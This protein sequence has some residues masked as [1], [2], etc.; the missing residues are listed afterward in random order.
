MNKGL[1][2]ENNIE[3]INLDYSKLIFPLNSGSLEKKQVF[4]INCNV[5]TILKCEKIKFNQN[6]K[7][8]QDQF[9]LT[10]NTELLNSTFLININVSNLFL[11]YREYA[12]IPKSSNAIKDF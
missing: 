10:L 12:M 1:S 9:K 4:F 2:K 11:F 6:L 8:N 3:D 5:S 7:T